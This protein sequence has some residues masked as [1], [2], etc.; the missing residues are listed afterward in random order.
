MAI[1]TDIVIVGGALAGAAL[2]LAL[3]KQTQWRITL[4]TGNAGKACA[5]TEQK[6]DAI[7]QKPNDQEQ[8]SGDIVNSRV[9]A[10]NDASLAFLRTLGICPLNDA[11]FSC[12]YRKMVV[13]DGE[14]TGSVD[15]NAADIHTDY[16]GVITE[17]K[18]LVNRLQDAVQATTCVQ[19]IANNAVVELT[20]TSQVESVIRLASG[21]RVKAGLIIAADGAHSF[22]REAAAIDAQQKPYGHSA[23]VATVEVSCDH[24][25]TAFQRFSHNGP[26]AFLPLP[27]IGDKHYCAIVWSLKN[28]Q[29]VE[30]YQLDDEAFACALERAI[31]G[32]LGSVLKVYHRAIVP[33]MQ[34]H[35][36]HYFREGVVLVGDAAHTLHPLAGQGVNLGFADVAALADELIRA[37]R[38]GLEVGHRSILM[39]YQR[40]RK[41]HNAL[42][43]KA[44][45]TF[46]TV[47]E[48][49]NPY[50]GLVRNCGMLAFNKSRWLKKHVMQL[51]SGASK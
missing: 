38:R 16:L 21:D 40:R 19:V 42:A 29:A 51:A 12:E 17:N 15:F 33:L 27:P 47:F 30:H 13:W 48:Q 39:R 41:L 8:N 28:D 44:M 32:R 20:Q 14:G 11:K 35:V 2:A 50:I 5:V 34:R 10:L 6:P 24:Q 36:D 25:A 31:E 7:D 46:K 43:V 18:C 1:Q 37:E 3:A 49:S 4:I 9:V 22:I 26:L 45:Y 23:I